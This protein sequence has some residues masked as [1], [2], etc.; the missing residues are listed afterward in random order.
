MADGRK[1]SV[2]MVRQ[3]T[4]STISFPVE[5]GNSFKAIKLA[6]TLLAG[7]TPMRVKRL[8][9]KELQEEENADE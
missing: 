2:V 5:A 4:G 3:N 1:Y 9:T 6:E 8:T 7:W